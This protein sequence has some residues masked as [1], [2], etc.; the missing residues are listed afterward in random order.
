MAQTHIPLPQMRKANCN[1]AYLR[2]CKRGD[3]CGLLLCSLWHNPWL[4]NRHP[5]D[6]D[7]LC[8]SRCPVSYGR[9]N[10]G[11]IGT[12]SR[13]SRKR[14]QKWHYRKPN[15]TVRKSRKQNRHHLKNKCR[16]G[17]FSPE[18]ILWLKVWKHDLWHR[19]FKNSDPEYIVKVLQRMMR[20]KGYRK[21]NPEETDG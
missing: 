12:M 21:E 6:I 11:R 16:G 18:N 7:Y 13:R 3:T 2:L 9:T 15:R 20:M 8:P 19:V 10:G 4:Q 5:K 14:Y 17:D 1:Y